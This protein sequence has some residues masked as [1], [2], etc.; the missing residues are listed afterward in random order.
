MTRLPQGATNLPAQFIRIVTKILQ[1]LIPHD[2]DSFVDDVGVK[3]L[4]SQYDDE[5]VFLGVCRFVI[6]HIQSLDK[7]LVHIERAGCMI[8]GV[9][10]QF[11]MDGIKIIGYICGA[12][13]RS[14]D[15]AKVIKILE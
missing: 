12:E 1:D 14:L 10:S 6:E 9:K 8:S 15:T 7:T 4:I 5:E 2:C 13:G 11:C 3:G